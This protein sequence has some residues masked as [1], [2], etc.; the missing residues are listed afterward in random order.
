MIQVFDNLY[1]R[2]S[3]MSADRYIAIEGI[4]GAGKTAVS[5]RVAKNLQSPPHNI[6]ALHVREPG[7][8]DVGEDVRGVLLNPREEKM[9][10]RAEAGLFAAA[11]AQLVEMVVAPALEAGKVVISDRSAYSSLAYQGGARGLGIE[12]VRAIND[13]AINGL[14]PNIVIYLRID[15]SIG[16][17][18][19][20]V[21][22]RIGEEGL[23]FQKLV[24]GAYEKLVVA[25]PEK[26]VIIDASMPFDDVVEEA[27]RQILGRL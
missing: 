6:D 13:F 12:D 24:A 18:R 27:T 3:E 10:N 21:R 26:F 22:D 8:T 17:A 1:K 2:R 7:G 5:A 19:E 14:W 15:P 9:S 16:F 11:R 25:E 23:E 4:E 20:R